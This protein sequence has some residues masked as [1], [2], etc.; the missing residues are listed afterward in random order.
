MK[1]ICICCL[2]AIFLIAC[3]DTPEDI[4]G[5]SEVITQSRYQPG[6]RIARFGDEL[7]L[8]VI[9]V[10]SK[11]NVVSIHSMNKALELNNPTCVS[12]LSKVSDTQDIENL[13]S[14]LESTTHYVW[15][16]E[17]DPDYEKEGGNQMG[18]CC[19]M[20]RKI[21]ITYSGTGFI[22]YSDF[23]WTKDDEDKK[24]V[25]PGDVDDIK[26]TLAKTAG[27][28]FVMRGFGKLKD[29]TD[30][31]SADYE[32]FCSMNLD[33]DGER[34]EDLKTIIKEPYGVLY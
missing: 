2:L 3:K 14:L 18:L 15:V 8:A 23:P 5:V 1:T 33:V 25:D 29:L 32:S 11:Q 17:I 27:N 16:A 19:S 26:T 31:T 30:G 10:D 22:E 21:T 6:T 24:I 28:Q 7:T 20:L 12:G 9:F 34:E 4:T 13:H